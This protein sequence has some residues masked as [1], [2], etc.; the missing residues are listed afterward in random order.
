MYKYIDYYTIKK[1]SV[2]IY[3]RYLTIFLYDVRKKLVFLRSESYGKMWQ[4][5]LSCV[6]SPCHLPETKTQGVTLRW[7]NKD[8]WLA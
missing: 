3:V 4:G 6:L 5:L 1:L 8:I 7:R 2:C